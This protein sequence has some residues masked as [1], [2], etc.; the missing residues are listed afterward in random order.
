VRRFPILSALLATLAVLAAAAPI[1]AVARPP[2]DW[3][4]AEREQRRH[5]LRRQLSEEQQRRDAERAAQASPH[6]RHRAPMPPGPPPGQMPPGQWHGAASPG[7]HAGPPPSQPGAGDAG[8]RL[9]PQERRELRQELRRQGQG[10]RGR[11][12]R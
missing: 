9:S 12:E 1:D 3:R 11:P 6:G 10:M 8:A 4:E 2:G 7:P 5:E